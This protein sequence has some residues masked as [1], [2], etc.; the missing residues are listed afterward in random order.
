MKQSSK[1]GRNE[2]LAAVNARTPQGCQGY[3][4][5]SL[6]LERIIKYNVYH[7]FWSKR[8]CNPSPFAI[9][10]PLLARELYLEPGGERGLDALQEQA[11]EASGAAQQYHSC[12]EP[13]DKNRIRHTEEAEWETVG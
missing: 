6:V 11:M 13:G 4:Q 9:Q 5:N 8:L 3:H 10:R 1:K 7:L 2:G 12:T